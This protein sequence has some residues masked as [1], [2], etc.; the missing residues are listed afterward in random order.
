MKYLATFASMGEIQR[1]SIKGTIY[2]YGGAAIGFLT[3]ALLFPRYLS[4]EEIGLINVLIAWAMLFEQV[5]G[6]GVTNIITR[7]F[8]YFRNS[9]GKHHGFLGLMGLVSALGFALATIAFFFL[10]DFIVESEQEKSTLL[11][12]FIHLLPI[13]IFSNIFFNLFDQYNKVLYKPTRGIVAREFS[14]RIFVLILIGAYIFKWLSFSQFIYAYLVVQ[15]LPMLILYGF[16]QKDKSIHFSINWPAFTPQLRREIITVGLFGLLSSATSTITLTIDRIMINRQLDLDLAGIYST[17][18]FFGTLVI[19]PS[20]AINKTISTYISEAWKRYDTEEIFKIYKSSSVNQFLI[21]TLLMIGIWANIENIMIILTESFRP[22]YWVILFIGLTYLSDMLFNSGVVVLMN[23]DQYRFSTYFI[24]IMTILMVAGNW[25]AIPIWSITGAAAASFV[26]RLVYNL[27][28]Y[29]YVW[30]K[31]KL[32]PY[33][34]RHLIIG[35]T[36]VLVYYA[37]TFLPVFDNYILDILIRSTLITVVYLGLNIIFKTSE[38]VDR[39]IKKY[40]KVRF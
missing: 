25:I 27:L 37:S 14:L 35:V 3:S 18:F 30:N 40:I 21:G 31:W 38:E 10:T 36:G 15:L 33:S 8:P 2:T 1:Q 7:V 5:F 4:T 24:I 17:C 32:Q 19:L 22:G 16:L 6:F 12:D 20:R 9:D 23:S 28:T 39:N 26:S 34:Y 29:F 13:F 11:R